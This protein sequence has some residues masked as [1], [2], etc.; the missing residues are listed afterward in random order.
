MPVTSVKGL[1]GMVTGGASGLGRA[2]TLRLVE[3]GAKVIVAID[4]QA[5]GDDI[6]ANK[7]I[8]AISGID[9]RKEADVMKAIEECKTKCGRLDFVVNCAGIASAGGSIYDFKTGKPHSLEAFQ[10]VLDVNLLGTFNVCRL[11]AGLIGKNEPVNG[12][13]GCIINTASIA[14]FDSPPGN[15]D[16]VASKG[17]LH[18]MTLVIARDLSEQMIRCVSI[19]PGFFLTPLSKPMLKDG[20]GALTKYTACPKRPGEPDEFAHLVQ[21]ILENPMLNGETIRIDAG[22]RMPFPSPM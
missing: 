5:F 22:M 18:S 15:V 12:V 16:Y 9:I 7:K 14:A 1:V 6:K 3:Q 17:A 11:A 20:L 13:R 10:K 4:F 8:V 2:T 21:A 19:A